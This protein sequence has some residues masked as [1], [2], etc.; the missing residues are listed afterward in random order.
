MHETKKAPKHPNIQL[1]VENFGPIEKAEID[2]R[3]LTVFVGESNTGKTYLSALIYALHQAFEGSSRFPWSRSGIY[4]LGY[5]YSPR[6]SFSSAQG[7]LKNEEILS[8]LEKLKTPGLPFKFSDLPRGIQEQLQTYLKNLEICRDELKRCFDLGSISELVR[9]TEN[10]TNK[11]LA[12]KL[13]RRKKNR[14][15]KMTVSLKIHEA[16]ELLWSFDIHGS[17]SNITVD[18][19]INKDMVIRSEDETA[20]EKM[21]DIEDL[22]TS[23]HSLGNEAGDSYYLPAARSGI[24]QSHG[25][26]AS[27]LVDRATSVGLER[28]PGIP[29]FSGMIADF[30]KQIIG[31]DEWQASSNEMISIAKALE[32]EVLRGEIEVRQPTRGYPEFRYRPQESEQ[33]LRMS[34]SSSMISELGPLVL[35]LRGVVQPGDTLIIEEPESHLHP[36]AQA[37]VALTL[38][39]LVRVGVRVIITTHSDWLLEQIG[40]LVREGEVMKLEKNKTER[41]T[42]LT[43]EEVGAWWF[44]TDKPVKEIPFEHIAGIEPEE[45]G[46]VAEKLYNRSVNLRTQ[47]EEA[48]GGTEVEQE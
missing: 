8:A 9:F 5:T 44:R 10:K 32:N 13:I 26:I 22:L 18:G 34:R 17:G 33:M 14:S 42:W 31:Y 43:K 21:N 24:M 27:S 19:S 36:A 46:E 48:E 11:K 6:Y 12:S 1:A 39:R 16:N 7:K 41:E 47:L 28:F 23:L 45:Y 40:N 37:K 25:V 30:L 29:T 35:F 38:T 4:E 15:N 3:P 20:F 2:L